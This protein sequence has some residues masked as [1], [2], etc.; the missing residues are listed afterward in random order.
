[1][2]TQANDKLTAEY[3]IPFEFDINRITAGYNGR[4]L[5]VKAPRYVV[6]KKSGSVRKNTFSA[7]NLTPISGRESDLTE[8]TGIKSF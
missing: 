7:E 8:Y 5:V 6:A 1:M 4:D 3:M 2:G